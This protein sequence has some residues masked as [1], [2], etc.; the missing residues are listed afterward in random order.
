MKK[1]ITLATAG[2]FLLSLQ[3]AMAQKEV[4]P[5]AV[6]PLLEGSKPLA[7]P[8]TREPVAPK[9]VEPEKAKSKAKGKA[10]AGPKSKKKAARKKNGK[11][12]KAPKAAK[13]KSS[14]TAKKKHPAAGHA[15]PSGPDE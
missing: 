1:F 6:P 9:Q 4:Q 7:T 15:E 11:K 2:I 8:E 5:P 3:G 10:K 12:P 13:R 14:K